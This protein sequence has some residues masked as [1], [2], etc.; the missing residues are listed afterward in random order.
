MFRW[1]RD[2]QKWEL[3]S[4][5]ASHCHTRW[6]N[7]LSTSLRL[8]REGNQNTFELKGYASSKGIDLLNCRQN[9]SAAGSINTRSNSYFLHHR[10]ADSEK[11]CCCLINTQHSE[12]FGSTRKRTQKS[13]KTNLPPVYFSTSYFVEINH[14]EYSGS[15]E[16]RAMA[17]FLERRFRGLRTVTTATLARSLSA[18]TGV[19]TSCTV[20]EVTLPNVAVFSMM[21]R[22]ES[23]SGTGVLEGGEEDAEGAALN[24]QQ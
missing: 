10:E 3:S 1:S 20:V 12:S 15:S 17:N 21:I 16:Q 22:T 7:F 19:R 2:E 8:L 13:S 4:S 5:C 18:G 14:G 11:R 23:D 6:S 9:G 24:T